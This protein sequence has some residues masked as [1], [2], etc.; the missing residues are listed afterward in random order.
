[1]SFSVLAATLPLIK[2][3]YATWGFDT[4]FRILAVAAAVI[5]AVVSRLPAK[6]PQPPS[7]ATV[8]IPSR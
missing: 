2:F 1:V 5:L 4:L 7:A 8:P 6:M 3:V